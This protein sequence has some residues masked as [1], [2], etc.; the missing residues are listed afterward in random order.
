MSFREY[1]GDVWYEVWRSSGNPDAVDTEDVQDYYEQGYYP[2]EAAES[3][4]RRFTLTRKAET[5]F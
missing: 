1:E 4:T 5:F 3:I 2:E